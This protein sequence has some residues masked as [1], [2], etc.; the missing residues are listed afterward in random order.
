MLAEVARRRFTTEEYHRMGNVGVLAPGERVELIDGAVILMS[1]IGDRHFLCVNRGVE[2]FVLA[3]TGKAV[4]SGQNPVR[5]DK[6]N[7]PQPDIVLYRP[8][9]GHYH[10]TRPSARNCYLVVEVSDSSLRYDTNFK[11]ALYAQAGVPEVWIEDLNGECL[12]VRRNLDK[13]VYQTALTLG[14][15]DVVSILAFPDV[16][17]PVR[18]LLLTGLTIVDSTETEQI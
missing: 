4:V 3:F 12:L 10:S 14:P 16:S 1:P 7:E 9:P 11:L 13:G 8:T 5:F 18:E 2:L 17:L 15:D 6:H